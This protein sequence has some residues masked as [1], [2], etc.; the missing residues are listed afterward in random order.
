M[1]VIEE[2]FHGGKYIRRYRLLR[3]GD[4]SHVHRH[5]FDHHMVI[6]GKACVYEGEQLVGRECS[7]GDIL[8]IEAG[9]WHMVE[10][11]EDGAVY[12]C[13]HQLRKL[14]GSI[15]TDEEAK[16]YTLNELRQLTGLLTEQF[17]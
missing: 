9:Q 3:A 11:R 16:T 13:T 15:L 4:Q 5:T 10:A 12:V 1:Q 8:V 7:P 17:E 2:G 6:C 14:D